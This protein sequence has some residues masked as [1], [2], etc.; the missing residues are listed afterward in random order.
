MIVKKVTFGSQEHWQAIQ[1]RNEFLRK[2]IGFPFLEDFPAEEKD[3]THY[4]IMDDEQQIIGC[5]VAI[6]KNKTTTRL[7]QMAVHEKYQHQGVGRQLLKFVEKNLQQEGIVSI[8]I[9]ARKEAAGFYAKAGYEL[10]GEEFL[11]VSIPHLV[12]IKKLSV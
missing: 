2:P 4:V 9:H 6:Q 11:E 3:W 12:M 7:R 5:L 1:L 10:Q 8:I